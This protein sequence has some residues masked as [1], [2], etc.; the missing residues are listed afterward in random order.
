MEPRKGFQVSA[1]PGRGNN[2][3][4]ETGQK[5]RKPTAERVP[6]SLNLGVRGKPDHT[7]KAAKT[8][9]VRTADNKAELKCWGTECRSLP[10]ARCDQEGEEEVS[11]GPQ[12]SGCWGL[13]RSMQNGLRLQSALTP[14]QRGTLGET[15]GVRGLLSGAALPALDRSLSLSLFTCLP[16]GCPA[17]RGECLGE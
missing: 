8:L 4:G 9:V 17:Q 3:L 14:H 10:G 13:Q 11:W 7:M 6:L 12:V 5:K 16:D 2:Q 15:G 1:R